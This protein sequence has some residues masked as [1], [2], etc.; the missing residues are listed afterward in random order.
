MAT[1]RR[2]TEVSVL[3]PGQSKMTGVLSLAGTCGF[4][5]HLAEG[6]ASFLGVILVGESASSRDAPPT[7]Y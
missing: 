7:G 5:E 4:H 2:S 6:A 3:T 1:A